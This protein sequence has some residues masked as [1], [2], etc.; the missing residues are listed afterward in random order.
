[1]PGMVVFLSRVVRAAP[2]P[3]STSSSPTARSPCGS[4]R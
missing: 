3:A 1:M 2:E 4:V